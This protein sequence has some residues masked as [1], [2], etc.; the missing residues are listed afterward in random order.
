MVRVPLVTSVE[1][2]IYLVPLILMMYNMNESTNDELQ[3][4][5]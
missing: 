5:C 3:P 2:I 4:I 1:A